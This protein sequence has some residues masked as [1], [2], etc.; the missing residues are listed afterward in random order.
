VYLLGILIAG[1]IVGEDL[2]VTETLEIPVGIEAVTGEGRDR[3]I[4]TG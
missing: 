4:E 3:G 2:I 1:M